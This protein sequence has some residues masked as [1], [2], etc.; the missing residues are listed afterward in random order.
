MNRAKSCKLTLFLLCFL[1]SVTAAVC[2][3]VGRINVADAATI[4]SPSNYF[5]GSSVSF[6]DG[7]IV[8][9]VKDGEFVEFSN[10]LAVNNAEMNLSIPANLTELKIT[11]TSDSFYTA[12]VVQDGGLVTSVDNVVTIKQN[13][14]S[15]NGETTDGVAL[16]EGDITVSFKVED[17]VLS[18][19][20]NDLEVANTD[21]FYKIG[22]KD[23]ITAKIRFD[24]KVDGEGAVKFGIISVDQNADADGYKQTFV[25]NEDG[26]VAEMA[27]PRISLGSVFCATGANDIVALKGNMYSVSFK[28]YSVFGQ[29][30][31]SDSSLYIKVAEEDAGKVWLQNSSKPKSVAFYENVTMTVTNGTTDAD[32]FN[33]TVKNKTEDDAAPVYDASAYAIETYKAAVLKATEEDYGDGVKGSV[34]LGESYEIPSMAN[35]VSDDLT[36]YADLT[37]TVYYKTPSNNSGSSTNMKITLTEAGDYEFFVVFSDKAGNSMEKDDFYTVSEEDDNLVVPGAYY[38]Y[39]F[40]FHIEDDAPILVTANSETQA[41]GYLNTRYTATA[42]TVKSSGNTTTY[43]LYYNASLTAEEDGEGWVKIP[44]KADTAADYDENGFTYDD[45]SDIDYDGSLTF[46][47]VKLGTYKIECVVNSDNSVRYS[48]AAELVVVDREA[49]VVKVPSHWLRDNVWSVVFLSIGTLSLV[50]IIVLLFI[51]PKEEIEKDETGEAYKKS[52][53]K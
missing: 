34:R 19:G 43:T 32:S 15:L 9:S 17:N 14:V 40:T 45:I 53:D 49:T 5:T 1:L 27:K 10:K 25:L 20:V 29:S 28:A 44:K 37:K 13:E 50:G 21:E 46:T 51:K 6:E 23:V 39:V 7:K 24:F 38:H 4:K 48:S 33:V 52:A 35:L 16:T 18:V 2:F 12:G 11:L 41:K 42:F 26:E 3:S 31:Y 8:S 47:P 30:V 36:T 22:G